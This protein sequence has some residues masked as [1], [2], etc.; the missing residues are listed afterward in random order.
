MAIMIGRIR[1]RVIIVVVVVVAIFFL[2]QIN[3]K[4]AYQQNIEAGRSHLST[5]TTTTTTITTTTTTTATTTALCAVETRKGWGGIDMSEPPPIE[6]VGRCPFLIVNDFRV[7]EK[8]GVLVHAHVAAYDSNEG[9]LLPPLGVKQNLIE[10][11]FI[12]TWPLPFATVMH[13]KGKDAFVGGER[14]SVFNSTH[15]FTNGRWHRRPDEKIVSSVLR[16]IHNRCEVK[17]EIRKHL[18]HAPSAVGN[19]SE[20]NVQEDTIGTSHGVNTFGNVVTV[21]GVLVN[22]VIVWG[23]T[24]QHTVLD[25]LPRLGALYSYL[26]GK[27]HGEKV[28]PLLFQYYYLVNN[29]SPVVEMLVELFRIPLENIVSASPHKVYTGTEGV[30]FPTLAGQLKIGLMP[31]GIFCPI[32]RQ[33][34]SHLRATAVRDRKVLLYLRRSQNSDRCM[35]KELEERLVSLSRD[36]FENEGKGWKLVVWDDESTHHWKT[37][38]FLFQQAR[39]IFGPHGGSF[40]NIIFAASPYTIGVSG[41]AVNVIEFIGKE[42]IM[43]GDNT[44]DRRPC[45]WSLSQALGLRYWNVETTSKFSFAA[46]NMEVDPRVVINTISKALST[47]STPI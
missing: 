46:K 6:I 39:V 21:K 37:D 40:S 24:Y 47:S 41:D 4:S 23:E 19:G 3:Q 26:P 2:S 29:G 15:L 10:I 7:L 16:L 43:H 32:L 22:L 9:S 18:P 45:Y 33:L 8:D 11:I 12:P 31:R 20:N 38:Q 44:V 28:A 27:G 13:L 14:G 25:I 1:I 5:T 35:K 30:L 36:T 42:N 34:H 17:D